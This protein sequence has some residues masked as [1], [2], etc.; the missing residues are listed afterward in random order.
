MKK[1]LL[2]LLF[3]P[4]VSFGQTVSVRDIDLSKTFVIR[5][6]LFARDKVSF[7]DVA[8]ED[9]WR[10]ALFEN[11]LDVGNY[12][13]E[14]V[15]KDTDNREMQLKTILNVNGDYLLRIDTFRRVVIED[16]SKQKFVGSISFKK[17]SLFSKK[18]L[19]S[20]KEINKAIEIMVKKLNSQN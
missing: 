3:V 2:V 12:D 4:L 15:A 7:G 6:S 11:G 19:Q 18:G 8:I 5:S 14:K 1:L 13:L 10:I 20:Q 9:L 17:G 16:V